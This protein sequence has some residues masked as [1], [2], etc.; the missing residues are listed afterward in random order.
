M[1]IIQIL[2]KIKEWVAHD[3]LLHFL[4]CY[5]LMVAFFPIIGWWTFL[6]TSLAAVLKEGV[7]YFIEKDNDTKAVTHD[8]IMDAIG[9]IC[10]T[11][12]LLIL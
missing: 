8:L 7:D 10:A 4:I 5:C 2:N 9:I 3:G 6:T 11:V 12:T 1:K